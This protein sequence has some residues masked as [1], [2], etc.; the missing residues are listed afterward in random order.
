M[1]KILIMVVAIFAISGCKLT[2]NSTSVEPKVEKANAQLAAKISSVGAI[3]VQTLSAYEKGNM[4]RANIKEECQLDKKLPEFIQSFAA[5]NGIN[6]QLE[7]KVTSATKGKALVVEIVDSVSQGHAFTGHRKFTKTKGTL[8][9]N[10]KKIA[11][12][13]AS[14]VSG[15]GFFGIYK[16][17]CSVLGRTVKTIGK[18]VAGWLKNPVDGAQLG[19]R[20]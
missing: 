18:D 2:G 1:N 17:S 12:F 9:E 11:S 15:G 20:L 7:N 4:I 10:G 13:T 16:G 8:Y 3:K 19:D 5:T 14:R 6:V